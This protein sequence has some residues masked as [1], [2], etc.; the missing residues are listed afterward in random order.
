MYDW[1]FW[2]QAFVCYVYVVVD[3]METCK[4]GNFGNNCLCLSLCCCRGYVLGY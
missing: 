1:E 2:Q 3:G 4:T